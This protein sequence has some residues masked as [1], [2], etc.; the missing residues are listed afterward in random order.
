MDGNSPEEG[1]VEV[2]HNG[3]WGSVCDDYWDIKDAT[4][5]CLELGFPR[6]LA[7]VSYGTFGEANPGTRVSDIIFLTYSKFTL[8][9]STVEKYGSVYLVDW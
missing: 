4:V 2:Y 5:V 3:E 9:Y 8:L 7:A 1:R 6:A